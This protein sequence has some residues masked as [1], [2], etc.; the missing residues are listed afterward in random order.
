MSNNDPKT[1]IAVQQEKINNINDKVDYI[2][3]VIVGGDGKNGLQDELNK[4]KR[5]L[6]EVEGG[7]IYTRMAIA[8]LAGL[9][10]LIQVALNI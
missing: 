7:I 9:V 5:Q 1:K 4:T 10:A 6:S 2:Y 8:V 3:K